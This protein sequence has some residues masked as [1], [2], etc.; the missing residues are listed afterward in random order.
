MLPTDERERAQ[1]HFWYGLPLLAVRPA[2]DRGDGG[3]LVGGGWTHREGETAR[4]VM[5]PGGDRCSA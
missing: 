2:Q 3:M 4:L 5:E 1:H